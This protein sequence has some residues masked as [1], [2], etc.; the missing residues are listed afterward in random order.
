[1]SGIFR[2]PIP[3]ASALLVAGVLGCGGRAPL[4]GDVP[5]SER[6]LPAAI[7][8]SGVL[9]LESWGVPPEDTVVTF[10]AVEPRV[11]LLRRGAPDNSIFAEL[12]IPPGTLLPPEGRTTATMTLRP[13]PGTFGLDVE[14]EAGSRM[15][16]G[17]SLTFSYAVHFV[18]PEGARQRYGSA[19][20][21][22]RELYVT[23][24][25]GDGLV[26]FLPSERPASDHLGALLTGPGRYL[27]AAPR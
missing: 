21:F 7:Q 23:Q 1:M 20:A 4:P 14:L 22:E 25:G 2:H 26:T 18:M 6:P 19:I 11:I 13:R 27:V 15:R 5:P 12:V 8:A 16:P 3:T 17:P 24:V 9:V 10:S